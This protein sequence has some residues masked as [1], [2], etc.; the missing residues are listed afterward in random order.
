MIIFIILYKRDLFKLREFCPKLHSL[1]LQLVAKRPWFPM[2]LSVASLSSELDS[3]LAGLV[4]KAM[5]RHSL[6]IK[7]LNR[8]KFAINL[9][10]PI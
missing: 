9:E 6:C 2:F 5:S 4:E 3:H 7:Y 10:C 8:L 1:C